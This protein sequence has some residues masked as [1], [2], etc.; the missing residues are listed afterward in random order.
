MNN[1][2]LHIESCLPIS[3]N[4]DTYNGLCVRAGDG[5]IKNTCTTTRNFSVPVFKVLFTCT[6][7]DLELTV[8]EVYQPHEMWFTISLGRYMGTSTPQ[9]H[10]ISSSISNSLLYLEQ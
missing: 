10:L 7:K 6:Q 8:K 3:T 5:T 9:D 4:I 2:A 1:L